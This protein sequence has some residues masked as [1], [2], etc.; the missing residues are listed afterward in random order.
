MIHVTNHP[1]GCILMADNMCNR[2]QLLKEIQNNG[3]M[4]FFQE[5]FNNQIIDASTLKGFI[6]EHFSQY[7]VLTSLTVAQAAFFVKYGA[8][9]KTR[10]IAKILQLLEKEGRLVIDRKPSF[11]QGS[12]KPSTFMTEGHGKTISIKW[13]R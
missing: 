9:C 3:Q 13:V 10:D 12:K 2:W 8:I 6:T 7:N 5:D 11:S 4:S 1:G